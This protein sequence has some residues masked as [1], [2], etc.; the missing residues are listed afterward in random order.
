[1]EGILLEFLGESPFWDK[2]VLIRC[3]SL[4]E[5]KTKLYA[6][7]HMDCEYV[8]VGWDKES[9]REYDAHFYFNGYYYKCKQTV[10]GDII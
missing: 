4:E 6:Q 9:I 5:F 8:P 10:I 7:F 1:M 2:I 3:T